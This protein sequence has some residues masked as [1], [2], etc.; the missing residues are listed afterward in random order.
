MLH[1]GYEFLFE[2][3]GRGKTVLLVLFAPSI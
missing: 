3:G 1:P 2:P